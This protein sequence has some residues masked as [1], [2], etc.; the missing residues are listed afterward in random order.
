MSFQVHCL[1]SQKSLQEAF[2]WETNVSMACNSEKDGIEQ[3]RR[4]KATFLWLLVHTKGQCQHWKFK[5]CAC[6]ESNLQ[7]KNI[8][9]KY[10]SVVTLCKATKFSHRPRWEQVVQ[11][12]WKPTQCGEWKDCSLLCGLCTALCWI[13]LTHLFIQKIFMENEAVYHDRCRAG[14]WASINASWR[15][16]FLSHA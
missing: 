3:F 4:F 7:R 10:P 8:K 5:T 14:P 2:S 6:F 11:S 12:G 16:T 1:N 9:K 15:W 13:A